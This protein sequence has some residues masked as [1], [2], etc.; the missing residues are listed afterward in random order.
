VDIAASSLRRL[1]S[2]PSGCCVNA[3]LAD[4]F[5]SVFVDD[6]PTQS[7]H[8]ALFPQVLRCLEQP[9]YARIPKRGAGCLDVL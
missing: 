5:P 8:S 4:Q 3:E 2:V 9:F 7:D 6:L 1:E